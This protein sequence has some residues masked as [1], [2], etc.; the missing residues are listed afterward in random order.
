MTGALAMPISVPPVSAA[1]APKTSYRPSSSPD[2]DTRV[3]NGKPTSISTVS[4]YAGILSVGVSNPYFAQ[5]C[6]GT[7]VS[8]RHVITAAHCVTG[9]DSVDV[10]LGSDDLVAGEGRRIRSR[11]I[12]VHPGWNP[13]TFRNDI[14]VV[15]LRRDA[16]VEPAL[17]SSN[18][19]N[20]FWEPGDRARVSGFGCRDWDIGGGCATYPTHLRTG[21]LRLRSYRT[22][23]N[24]LG[25]NFHA[26]TMTCAGNASGSGT[27]VD[28]CAG[29]SGGPLVSTGPGGPLL[30]GIV[31][32]GVECG[33]LPGAYTRVAQYSTFLA[34]NGVPVFGSS[35]WLVAA[36]GGVFAY[37]DAPYLGSLGNTSLASRIV[38]ITVG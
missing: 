3:V 12:T 6:G 14:A 21:R 30:G 34:Q 7:V 1:N 17:V 15:E 19:T 10:L 13:G 28:S 36:D 33:L 22:C 5:Y 35:Y 37:G 16:N 26:D 31:S 8:N 9:T 25:S 23:R 2:I 4:Y 27:A 38:G 18:R 24:A 32:W 29:D 20:N 11:R